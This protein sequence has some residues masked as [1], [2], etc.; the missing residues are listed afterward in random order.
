MISPLSP[1]LEGYKSV[2]SVVAEIASNFV[3]AIL[4]H[5]LKSAAHDF[6]KSDGT[7]SSSPIDKSFSLS[8]MN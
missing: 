8:S 5:L 3:A 4:S 2:I 7:R 1:L 6:A